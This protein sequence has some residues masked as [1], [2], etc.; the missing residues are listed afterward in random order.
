M[1]KNLDQLFNEASLAISD[2]KDLLQLDQ[3]RTS[4][5]GKKGK[6]TERLK[7]LGQLAPAERPKAGQA[8]N[9]VKQQLTDLIQLRIQAMNDAQ[10]EANLAAQAVDITLPGRGLGLGN[11]HPITKARFIL[12]DF[13]THLGFSVIEGPEIEDDY[14]NFEALN[15][16]H[17]HP[18]KASHDTFY[19][20]D[21]KLLR[22]HT[23]PMQIRYMEKNPTPPIQIIVPGRVYRCDSDSTHAPMFNQLEGLVVAEKISFGNLKWLLN[24]MI[25]FFFNEKVNVRYRPSYFPFV[26]PGAE[27]DIEWKTGEKTRWLEVL[28]CGMVH[29]N[30]LK[31]VG[32]DSKRYSGFAFGLGIDRFAMLRFG[33]NDIRLLFENDLEFLQQF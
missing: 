6:L 7:M 12:E 21:G 26:E 16:P 29:P 25:E 3:I 19:F 17:N 11:I 1:D 23:S 15:F 27:V 30:V 8:I 18:A 20:P 4:Y 13:F 28:G 24:N 33:I 10:L 5:L 32:I 9:L 31:A 22:T 2:A 14:H